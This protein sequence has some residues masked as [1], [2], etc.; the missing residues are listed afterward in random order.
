MR[1]SLKVVLL[2]SATALAAV[3]RGAVALDNGLGKL[4]GLGW[5]S[6]YCTNCTGSLLQLGAGPNSQNEKFVK[7]IADHIHTHK[8][9]M[10]GGGMKTMQELGFH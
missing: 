3:L 8:Y 10:T 4:P 1:S 2:G 5:N 9:K 7:H 6:D